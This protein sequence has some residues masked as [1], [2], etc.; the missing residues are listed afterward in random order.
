MFDRMYD[1]PPPSLNVRLDV[2]LPENPA[3]FQRAAGLWLEHGVELL[4]AHKVASLKAAP[5][6][7]SKSLTRHL[8]SFGEPGTPWGS[9]VVHTDTPSG[10]IGIGGSLRAWTQ[11]NWDSF[12]ARDLAKLPRG[13]EA[14]FSQLDK[15][16]HPGGGEFVHLRVERETEV[17]GWTSMMAHRQPLPDVGA[18]DE[19]ALVWFEFLTTIV[20]EL[21]PYVRFGCIGED[22]T[23][24]PTVPLEEAFRRWAGFCLHEGRL[25]GYSWVTVLGEAALERVGGVAALERSG[26]FD[27]VR[28]LGGGA[29]VVRATPYPSQYD[30]E[31]VEK[32]FRALAAALPVGEPRPDTRDYRKLVWA[33]AASV[34]QPR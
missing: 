22:L 16:G 17:D 1:P 10:G 11:K 29:V 8:G 13:V 6:L 5:E 7:P 24:D 18:R 28:D 9:L 19:L 31:A 33:D 15:G 30:A 20:A 14:K 34:G 32:V 4:A 25:R 23:I 27:E 3:E 26:A 21:G 12:I 2:V